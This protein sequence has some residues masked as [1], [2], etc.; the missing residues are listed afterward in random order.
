MD[1]EAFTDQKMIIALGVTIEGQKIPLGFVQAS[2]KMS[3]CAGSLS[4]RSS[5]EGL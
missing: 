2:V 4:I 1:G 5:T 3:A